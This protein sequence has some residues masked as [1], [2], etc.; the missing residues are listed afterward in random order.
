MNI[1]AF[2]IFLFALQ[3]VCL[4]VGRG[5]SKELKNQEDYFLAGRGIKFFPL[6]MTFLATQVGGGL[7]LGSAEEAYQFG[8]G[9]LLYPLGASLG[10]MLLGC[11]IGSRL[12]QFKVST[13][14]QI[15][16]VVYGSSLLKKSA[17]LLSIISLFLILIGQIIASKKFMVSVGAE[18]S[19][20]FLAFWAIVIMYTAWGGLK[21][22]VATDVVQ[23]GFFFGTFAIVLFYGLYSS[24]K[25][26]APL[27]ESG[28]Q[29]EWNP[30]KL[31]SW[32]ILPL[33]FMVIEQDMG[34]R[35]FAAKSPKT[36]LKASWWAAFGTLA[37]CVVPIYFA[38]VAKS[39]GLLVPEGGS[40]LMAALTATTTPTLTALV[41]CAI[42][43]A[44]VSTAD[45]L[46]N[47]IGCN[48]AQDFEIAQL[49]RVGVSQAISAL[50]AVS[51]IG[52]AF[53]FNNVV[54]MLM[55]SYELSVS[56][57]FV[58]IFVAFFKK[59]GNYP[60]AI[61]AIAGGL[62]GFCLFRIFPIP[63]PKE[64]ASVALSLVGYGIGEISALKVWI[65]EGA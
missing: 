28:S 52:A 1:L 22:V 64:I 6:M 35:C 37:I 34:Q 17:S 57:L 59:E 13:V 49:K 25:P 8:W 11:G 20:L 14:A 4:L 48:L 23:A 39:S 19:F 16:E 33:L 42:L 55:L 2:F 30:S 5:F 56:C 60:S 63:F 47:A 53:F 32:L 36:V 18:S 3:A 40:V 43:A 10:L 41:G 9:V 38:I 29:F 15:L 26:L 51:A 54:D 65:K 21:A 24:E 46:I 12:A 27:L 50:I 58:P 7:I 45:S 44:I 61:L 62:A 31:C